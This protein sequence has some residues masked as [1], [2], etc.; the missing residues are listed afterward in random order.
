MLESCS[1]DVQEKA[2]KEKKETG[3]K[4]EARSARVSALPFLEHSA[5]IPQG[6]WEQGSALQP[7]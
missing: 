3:K 5:F 1:S 2:L 6:D 4:E 7:V